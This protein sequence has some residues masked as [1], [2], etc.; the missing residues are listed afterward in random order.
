MG[1]FPMEQ[2]IGWEERAKS[3]LLCQILITIISI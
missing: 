1:G 2:T 3:I